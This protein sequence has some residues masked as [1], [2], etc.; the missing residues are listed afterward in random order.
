MLN[1]VW[2]S[3]VCSSDQFKGCNEKYWHPAVVSANFPD[4]SD[5]V[6]ANALLTQLARVPRCAAVDVAPQTTMERRERKE[7]QQCRNHFPVFFIPLKLPGIRAW[8]RK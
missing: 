2:I 6:S 7:A 4:F 8:N 3:D 1:S 5:L